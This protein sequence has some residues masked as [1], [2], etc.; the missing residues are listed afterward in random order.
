MTINEEKNNITDEFVVYKNN[1]KLEMR[2]EI[3][4]KQSVR[5]AKNIKYFF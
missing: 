4:K 3:F 2:I 5:R 1:P